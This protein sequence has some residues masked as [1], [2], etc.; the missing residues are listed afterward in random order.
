MNVNSFLGRSVGLDL[1]SVHS[2][3]NLLQFY[4]SVISYGFLGDVLK[5]SEKFRWMGP[6]RYEYSGL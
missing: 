1:C 3:G 4:S 6:K 2:N 5:E